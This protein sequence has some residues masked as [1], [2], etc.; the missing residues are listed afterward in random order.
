MSH[1]CILCKRNGF[2]S[3]MYNSS[4]SKEEVEGDIGTNFARF[5]LVSEYIWHLK[6]IHGVQFKDTIKANGKQ[7]GTSGCDCWEGG[8]SEWG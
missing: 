8:A 7:L 2:D 5:N 1:V 3:T 4:S 6:N